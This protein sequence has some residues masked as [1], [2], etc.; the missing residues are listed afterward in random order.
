MINVK[1][2]SGFTLVEIAIVLVIIG[3]LLGGI[4]KGQELITSAR[5][6][7]LADQNS[8]VQA[9]Y[10]G[11]IDRFRAIPGDMNA[12]AAQNAVGV[13]GLQGGDAD[14]TINDGSIAEASVVWNHLAA[15][16]FIT[17][18]Y[19]G[20]GATTAN[21]LAGLNGVPFAPANAFQGAIMLASQDEYQIAAGAPAQAVRLA[22]SFGTQIPVNVLRELDVKI[23]DSLPQA[24]I[25]R[26]STPAGVGAA[27]FGAV[28]APAAG[29][30]PC[31]TAPL[32]GG[33]NQ[34]WNIAGNP[35]NCNALY[36]Y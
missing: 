26:A 16:N 4:L 32:G 30:A 9:A 33:A 21:Y 24:G 19:P 18:T 22:F 2:Q 12:I 14:G 5:V 35:Q 36:I 13:A 3:L 20:T 6:R 34:I 28:N 31:V 27:N 17:G 8:G 15:A 23:D 1:K 7:N 11:F 10:Y 25:L 29:A